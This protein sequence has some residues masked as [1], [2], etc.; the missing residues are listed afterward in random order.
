MVSDV[1]HRSGT[2]QEVC[3]NCMYEQLLKFCFLDFL[4]K[5]LKFWFRGIMANNVVKI[6]KWPKVFLFGDSLTQQNF[7]PEGNPVDNDKG[8]GVHPSIAISCLDL[9]EENRRVPVDDRAK[10]QEA[11]I[12]SFI[13]ENNL[14]LSISTPFLGVVEQLIKDPEAFRR[15][16]L[17]RTT[18]SYKMKYGLAK[19]IKDDLLEVLR[20]CKF[21]LNI[22]EAMNAQ[23]EKILTI[24]CS[25]YDQHKNQVL[26]NHLASIEMQNFSPEGCWGSLLADHL[27]RRC[28]IVNRGFSGYNTSFCKLM[29]P[30]VLDKQT[31]SETVALTIL[32][33]SNDSN[34]KDLNPRQHCPLE[35]YKQNLQEMVEF[36]MSQGVSRDK[37]ILITPPAVYE[38]DWIDECK[39]NERQSALDNKVTAQYVKACLEVAKEMGTQ[40]V[41]IYAEMMKAEDYQKYLRDG[42]HFTEK[43][44]RLLFSLLQPIIDSLTSHLPELLFPRWDAIDLENVKDSLLEM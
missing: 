18:A 8:Y 27:I 34:N 25:H 17:D 26:I 20:K 33:G 2:E 4:N 36:V 28:D 32:L 15:V 16:C 24:V 6:K 42:L 43:G 29:L 44:S 10:N 35:E 1:C 3:L 5:S 30:S 22:D 13:A 23:K 37:I 19:T 21:S 41:D 39:R 38:P 9:T 12:L 31:A 40:E 11:M 7:S 14:P